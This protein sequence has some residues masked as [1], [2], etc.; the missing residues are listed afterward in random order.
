MGLMT[1][2]L[3]VSKLIH[4]LTEEGNRLLL[5]RKQIETYES[6]LHAPATVV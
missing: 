5:H 1:F 6:A 2:N 4:V 3:L